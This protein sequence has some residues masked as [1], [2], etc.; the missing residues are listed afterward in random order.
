MTYPHILA[1]TASWFISVDFVYVVSEDD[2][3]VY[4][5]FGDEGTFELTAE[6]SSRESR[7]NPFIWDVMWL[8]PTRQCFLR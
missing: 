3:L 1:V 6:V 7:I 8:Y 4:I 5:W 2:S